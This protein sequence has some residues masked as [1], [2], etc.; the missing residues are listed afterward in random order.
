MTSFDFS[1]STT[2]SSGVFWQ[3]AGYSHCS[4]LDVIACGLHG[5][6]I[7]GTSSS[8]MSTTVHISG[9]S[10]FSATPNGYAAKLTECALVVF[11]G[12]IMEGTQG[13]L[14]NGNDNRALTFNNV[15]QEST[16]GNVFLNGGT[17]S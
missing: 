12:C 9:Q 4:H 8:V 10:R 13:I 15:Y 2:K 1:N 6:E 3:G 16:S 17:S 7:Y 5:I 11:D 14:L